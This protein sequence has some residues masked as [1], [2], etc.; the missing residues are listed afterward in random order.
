MD[1]GY[2]ILGMSVTPKKPAKLDFG[3]PPETIQFWKRLAR[4]ALSLSPT[5]LYVFSS[6]PIAERMAELDAALASAGFQSAIENRQSKIGNRK[7]PAVTGSRS[8]PNPSVR[9]YAGGAR[10]TAPSKSSAN[11]NCTPCS[12]KASL[13]KPFSS[14]GRLNIRGCQNSERP[15]THPSPPMGERV[16]EGRVRGIG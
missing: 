15:L 13:R 16:A 4:E 6:E 8:R 7:F 1:S 2:Q 14:T 10:K 12:P 3:H 9:C 11:W 5:P